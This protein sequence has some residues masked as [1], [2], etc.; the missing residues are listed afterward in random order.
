MKHVLLKY[1]CMMVENKI[2]CTLCAGSF[3]FPSIPPNSDVT[4][5]L[6]LLGFDDVQ[7]VFS[8]PKMFSNN[9]WKKR[10]KCGQYCIVKPD[11]KMNVQ[12]LNNDRCKAPSSCRV[13]GL[14]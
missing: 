5:E 6:E 14:N 7:E 1:I 2:G 12:R 9:W 11:I 10:T 8:D 3:S 13:S 4:Y